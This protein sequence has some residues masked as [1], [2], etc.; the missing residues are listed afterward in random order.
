VGC[1]RQTAAEHVV[2][3][4]SAVL[5]SAFGRKRTWSTTAKRSALTGA[6]D[7]SDR[8]AQPPKPA[9]RKTQTGQLEWVLD[10]KRRSPIAETYADDDAR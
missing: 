4:L 3:I 1:G 5:I 6:G 7:Q 8:Y 9:F 10:R 2:L